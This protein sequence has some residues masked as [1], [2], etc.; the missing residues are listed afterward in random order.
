MIPVLF[1]SAK[2]AEEQDVL[3]S[4]T[5]SKKQRIIYYVKT[6]GGIENDLYYRGYT[7]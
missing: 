4:H 7:P 2:A 1:I 6:Q 3:Q 5:F